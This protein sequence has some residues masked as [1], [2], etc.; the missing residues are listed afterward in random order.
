M[1]E[2]RAEGGPTM[3]SPAP[4]AVFEI[5][6]RL[7]MLTACMSRAQ[8][9]GRASGVRCMRGWAKLEGR[10][11]RIGTRRHG[12]RVARQA[13]TGTRPARDLPGTTGADQDLPGTGRGG[14]TTGTGT[15]GRRMRR[16][17]ERGTTGARTR[18]V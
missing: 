3:A 9:G 10:R 15:T 18:P 6:T 8:V 7:G 14:S 11:V 17:D 13:Q 16:H 4:L 2:L 5:E 1:R 12:T